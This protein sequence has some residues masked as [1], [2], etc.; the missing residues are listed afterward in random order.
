MKKLAATIHVPG[1]LTVLAALM[2]GFASPAMAVSPDLV[3]SQ[4]YGAGGNANTTFFTHDY[5]EI[6]NRGSVPVTAEGWSVQYGSAT[7]TGAWSGKSSLPTFTVEPGQYVLI[8]QQSGGTGQ[9]SLPTPVIVPQSGFNMSGT[10]GKV[11]LVR[12][13]VTLSGATPTSANIADLVGFGTANGAEGT[14]APAMSASLALFRAN[15]GCADT[16]DNSADFATGA[17]APRT[18]ASARN[19]CGATVPQAKPIVPVCPASLAIEQGKPGAAL[20]RAS[21][22]DSIVDGA[23][24]ASGGVPGISLGSLT[25]ASGNGGFASVNLQAA[26]SLA[27]GSYPLVIRFTNNAGQEATCPVNV[28]VSGAATIP[29]IQGAGA[30]SPFANVSVSTQG[31]VTHKVSN[32]YFIQDANGDGDP[33]TSDGLFVFTG[34]APLVA[35]GDLVRVKGTIVEYRPTGALRTYTEMKDVT[36]TDVL[37]SGNSVT[38]ANIA[39]EPGMDLARFEAMLVNI[40]NSL[41]VNQTNYLGDRGELTLSVGRRETATNRFRPGTPEALALAASN[42]SNELV[43]DDSW[44]V[45]PTDIPYL[46]QDGTVRAGDTVSSLVGVVDFGAIGGGRTAFKIQPTV[47]PSFTRSNPRLAAPELPVGNVKVASANVLNFFTTFLD[48]ADAWGRTGQGCKVG[49]TTRASNCRGADNMVEFVRQRDK[50]VNELKAIDADVVG[51]MEIQNNDDIAVDYLVKQLNAAIGFETYAY[52]PKPAATGTDAIR[53]AMIYKPAKVAL[54]GGALSDG[55]AVNNRPPMAQSFKAG[56]GARFSVIVN[57][58]K[59]K[60]GCGSGANADL[61][62][63]QSC[64]NATRVQQAQRLAS[65]FIPQVVAAA[66]DP[67]VLVIGDMNA[68]GFEDPIHLLNQAGLVNE[69]ERFVR[70]AGIPYSYVF[71]GES[72]YLDHALASA[73]LDAQVI[74]ATEWH[75]NADEPTVIDYNL[76]AKSAAAQA[77]FKNDAFRSSDHDPVVVALDLAPAYLDVTTSFR[78]QRSGV[79]VDRVNNKFSA[80]VTLT[81]TS[82]AAI[83]GPVHLLLTGLTD[84]VTLDNPSGVVGNEPYVTVNNATIPVGAKITFKVVFSNPARRGIGFVSKILSG[85]I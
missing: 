6:F 56:N 39:F 14:R 51:L 63:G 43:L 70:P 40:T 1:R 83:N 19:T 61:G 11:A 25:A 76:D 50:I 5:I 66:G 54:V 32:G 85:S 57:H 78:E 24:I 80:T 8:Q 79:S 21:D 30:A 49:S 73:S 82:G 23:V 48:G 72:G 18:S 69:L 46:G 45:T 75:T 84:G 42:A 29:Q 27:S 62:D 60:G 55:D 52:V 44:F 9:P 74:G 81:N 4:V 2:A 59:S 37:G 7:S 47:A 64:N 10:T 77:L 28:S 65:Y 33:A 31:V 58:L 20:L 17:P 71:D 38:P 68:H 16:D 3:I 36:G 15:G 22:E 34:T 53:V 12:D 13:T 35:V 67:D 26:A 41:T